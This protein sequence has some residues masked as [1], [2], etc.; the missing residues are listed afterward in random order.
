VPASE[1]CHV[2]CALWN[3]DVR[4]GNDASLEPVILDDIPKASFNTATC[5]VCQE[6]AKSPRDIATFGVALPCSVPH[7]DRYVHALW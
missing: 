7:C 4:F 2:V 5:C 3:K 6:I 1:F